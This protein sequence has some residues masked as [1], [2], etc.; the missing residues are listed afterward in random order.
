M[1]GAKTT[2]NSSMF[3]IDNILK[4]Q[5]KKPPTSDVQGSSASSTGALTLAEKLAGEVMIQ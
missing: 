3:T 2:P 4:T 1:D 5:P